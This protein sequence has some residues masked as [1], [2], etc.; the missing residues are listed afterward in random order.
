MTR[1]PTY[2]LYGEDEQTAAQD[3]LH[4]ETI[5]ARSRLHGF[6]IAPHRH[7]HLF[8]VLSLTAGQ[9]VITLD[10][11]TH[12]MEP[13]SVAILPALTVHGYDFSPDV[14]GIVLTMMQR[15]ALDSGAVIAG[16]SV[17]HGDTAIPVRQALS[18][19]L[20]EM[21]EPAAGRDIAM[22]ARIA[23]LMVA[24]S[25][26]VVIA[27]ASDSGRDPARSKAE[28][29]QALVEKWFR[30][31]RSVASYAQEIGISQTHLGRICRE[32]LG[33]SPLGVIERRIALEARRML[34]FS[35][36][37]VKEIGAELGYDDPAYFTRALT[38]LLGRS[39]MAFRRAAALSAEA[40]PP[41]GR[42]A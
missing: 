41:R 6:T 21:N 38:R 42:P 7:G 28:A 5:P 40:R 30:E 29:F 22:R 31:S 33:T 10:G 9:A 23:L 2:A 26:A 20:A 4:W 39:P 11:V 12:R 24:L 13:P 32:V 8:Q 16:P 36:L 35:N 34:L 17:I 3:W 14:D 27:P 1:I 15:D 25:R 18:D 19:L 37:S